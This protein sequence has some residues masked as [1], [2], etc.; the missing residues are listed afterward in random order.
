[1]KTSRHCARLLEPSWLEA[2]AAS[3]KRTKTW[4]ELR[5]GLSEAGR[6]GFVAVLSH[7]LLQFTAEGDGHPRRFQPIKQ[8]W[9]DPLQ[10]CPPP[11]VFLSTEVLQVRDRSCIGFKVK[12]VQARHLN[13]ERIR[14]LYWYYKGLDPIK[15]WACLFIDVVQHSSARRLAEGSRRGRRALGHPRL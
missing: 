14:R 13:S 2:V 7:V 4:W 6:R 8:P 12:L 11:S 1:M 15:R 9:I 5:L 3:E 10:V